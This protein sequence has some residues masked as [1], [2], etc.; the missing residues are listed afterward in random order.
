MKTEE[1]LETKAEVERERDT[2]LDVV[3]A[4]VV[5]IAAIVRGNRAVANRSWRAAADLLKELYGRDL[6][7]LN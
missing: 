1:E 2:L 5:V 6:G 3:E 4:L 7:P